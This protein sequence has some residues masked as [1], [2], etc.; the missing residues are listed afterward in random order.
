M[1]YGARVTAA[2]E[3]DG[4]GEKVDGE[5]DQRK[6]KGYPQ[7]GSDQPPNKGQPKEKE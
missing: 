6:H 7:G 3:A 4:V 2:G 1:P 5:D